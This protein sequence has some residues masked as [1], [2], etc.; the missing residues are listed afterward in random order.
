MGKYEV[1]VVRLLVKFIFGKILLKFVN[2][3]DREIELYKNSLMGVMEEVFIFRD[4]SLG[5]VDIRLVDIF[6]KLLE[7]LVLLYIEFSRERRWESIVKGFIFKILGMFF[8]EF[9]RYGIY[10]YGGV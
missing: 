1:L 10:K 2:V 5:I 8:K 3:L 6:N 9:W 4:D 7:Y